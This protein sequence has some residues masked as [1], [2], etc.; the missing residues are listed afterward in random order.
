[1]KRFDFVIGY[2]ISSVKR[3]R[4]VAKLLEV[5]AI[6]I[7]YSVFIYPK[8]TKEELKELIDKLLEIIDKESDDIRI[9]QINIKH[10]LNLKSAIDLAYPKLFIGVE[11]E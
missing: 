9:Y 6:R 5:V 2:D 7:Q 4:K 11:D 3:L 8:V 10:S 1:M